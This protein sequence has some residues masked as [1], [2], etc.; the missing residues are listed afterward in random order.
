MNNQNVLELHTKELKTPKKT[1]QIIKKNV[2]THLSETLAKLSDNNDDVTDTTNNNKENIQF[3]HKSLLNIDL[4]TDEIGIL[5]EQL[6]KI[7]TDIDNLFNFE[8][9]K[10]MKQ[11]YLKRTV[12]NAQIKHKDKLL[13]FIKYKGIGDTEGAYKLLS[14]IKS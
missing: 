2:K 10:Q 5:K 13:D 1:K 11:L 7:E 12:L 4:L 9:E 8:Y 3:D 14:Y 6:L